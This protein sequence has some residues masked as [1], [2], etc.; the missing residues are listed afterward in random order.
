MYEKDEYFYR[1]VFRD[2]CLG[3]TKT[4]VKDN[5]LYAKHLHAND[6]IAVNEKEETFLSKAKKRGLPTEEEA[7]KIIFEDD[8]WTEKDENFL[9][10][11]QIFLENLQRTKNNLNL[12]S[13]KDRHQKIIDEEQAKFNNKKNERISL[14]GNTAEAYASKQI[15]DYFVANSFYLDK[16]FKKRF[17]SDQDFNELS[18]SDI[19]EYTKVNNLMV[20]TFCEE[21]IQKIVLEEFFFPFMYISEKPTELFGKPAIELNNNQL[22][23]LTYSRIFRNIFDNNQDIPSKIRKDPAA[24]LDFASNSKSREKMKEHLDKDGA[25]TVFGAT[26]EDYEYMGVDKSTNSITQAAKKK[27]GSLNMSDLMELGGQG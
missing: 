7:L 23:I 6:Y 8:L 26:K 2:V 20:S 17:L 16:K 4:S 21:N 19:A 15:N 14:L 22:S 10:T 1:K 3:Y 18:Y 27:G 9:E 12:K 24:L 11:Q 25:S 13:E 5:V